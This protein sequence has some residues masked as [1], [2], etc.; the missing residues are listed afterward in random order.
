MLLCEEAFMAG[1]G[2]AFVDQ[3]HPNLCSR[4]IGISQGAIACEAD[5]FCH[6]TPAP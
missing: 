1:S 6:S 2:T 4:T 3:R 5:A